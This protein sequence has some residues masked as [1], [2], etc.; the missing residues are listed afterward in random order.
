[1]VVFSAKIL[2]F[3]A[4]GG[5]SYIRLSKAQSEKINPACKKSYRVRGHLDAH[6]VKHLALLPS[7]D[8]SFII[9]MNAAIRKGT[10]K[11]AG[12]TVKVQLELDDR[13]MTMSRDLINCL[14]DDKTAYDYFKKLPRGHQQYFSNWVNSAKTTQTRT[15]RVTMAV[16]A[17]SA[18]K[19]FGEMIREN[20]S[21][22]DR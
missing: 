9:P 19:G 5:W 6:E 16:I 11:I 7:G 20:K 13:P 12:D 10:G 4:K 15:K 21:S 22:N 18:H 2:K 14:K 3:Q 1:M 8:G 17:L